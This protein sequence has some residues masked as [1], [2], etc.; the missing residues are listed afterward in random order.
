MVS[1]N[2]AAI[3]GQHHIIVSVVIVKA[4]FISVDKVR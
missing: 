2:F 4:S 1:E 3:Y